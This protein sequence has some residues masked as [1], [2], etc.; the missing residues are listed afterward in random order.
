MR[1]S[2]TTH[3]PTPYIEIDAKRLDRNLRRMQAK[4]TD[5]RIGLRPHAKTHKSIHIARRQLELGAV[6]LTVSKPSEAVV[7]LAAGFSDVLLAYPVIDAIS[8]DDM[9]EAAANTDVAFI[10]DSVKG[11]AALA[12]AAGRHGRLLPVYLK[13]DVG[14]GRVGVLPESEAAITVSRAIDEA[15]NLRFAGLLSHAGHAY[16]AQSVETISDIAEKEMEDLEQLATRLKS[17]GLADPSISTGSTPTALGSSLSPRVSEVRPGNYA[18]L[19]MTAA[20]LGIADVEC[21][22]RRKSFACEACSRERPRFRQAFRLGITTHP[23]RV[24]FCSAARFRLQFQAN[25]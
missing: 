23:A 19:N 24:P 15:R 6:G 3:K 5:A 17:A 4:A 7:F 10:T 25:Y 9:L 8:I 2:R 13:V 16:A 14:L 21:R 11:V 1:H 22:A 18:L 20:R 12:V